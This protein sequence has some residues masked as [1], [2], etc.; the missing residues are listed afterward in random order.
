LNRRDLQFLWGSSLGLAAIGVAICFV[1]TV[2]KGHAV[3]GLFGLLLVFLGYKG[4]GGAW[5]KMP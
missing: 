3:F 1:A 2:T 5:R 4:L